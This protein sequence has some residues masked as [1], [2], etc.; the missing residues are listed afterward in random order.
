[1]KKEKLLE[2][3]VPAAVHVAFSTALIVLAAET[4][5]SLCHL[6]KDVKELKERHGILNLIE[7]KLEERKKK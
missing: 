6:H 2:V 3:L 1:M 5:K 4:L 7:E